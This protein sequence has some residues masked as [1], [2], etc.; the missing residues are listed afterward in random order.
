MKRLLFLLLTLAALLASLQSAMAAPWPGV[1]ESV[2]EKFAA[3][4]GHPA[5]EPYLNTDQGDLLL[6]V[7]LIAGIL[8]GFIAGYYFHALFPPRPRRDQGK[9][10]GCGEPAGVAPAP[11]PGLKAEH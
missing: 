7:F 11:V 1:D 9:G 3:A 10:D 6:F 5:R 2:I 8:G 4:A